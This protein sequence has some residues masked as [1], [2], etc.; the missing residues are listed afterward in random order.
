MSIDA[1]LEFALLIT[2]DLGG[3]LRSISPA[4]FC[5]ERNHLVKWVDWFTVNVASQVSGDLVVSNSRIYGNP[6]RSGSL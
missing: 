5:S 2:P 4:S 3:A 6:V 1:T